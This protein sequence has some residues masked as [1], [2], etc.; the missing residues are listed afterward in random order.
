MYSEVLV[1][2]TFAKLGM[3]FAEVARGD[4]ATSAAVVDLTVLRTPREVE[5]SWKLST[6]SGGL[7]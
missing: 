2:R 4:P 5:N 7:A 1:G 6:F 3:K